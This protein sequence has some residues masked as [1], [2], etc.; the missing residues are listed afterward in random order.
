MK[1]FISMGMKSKSTEQVKAE[2]D[3]VKAQILQKLPEAQFIDSVIDG[4]DADIA[5]EGDDKALWYLSKSL[6][7]MAGADMVFFI[8]DYKEFRGCSVERMVAEKYGKLC[9]EF[10]PE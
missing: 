1:I 5:V 2:M 4:A 9:V 6:E 3:K 8:G 10:N 7:M